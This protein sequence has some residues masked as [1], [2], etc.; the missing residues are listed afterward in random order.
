MNGPASV[1]ISGAEDAVTAIADQLR[2]DGRRVHQLAVSHAFHSPLMDPMID[3]FGTVAAGLTVGKPSIPIVS[4]LTGQLA[5][6]DFASAGVLEAAR[7]RRG[8]VR[9]QRP[10][11]AFGRRNPF[12]RSRAQRGLTASIEESLADAAVKPVR[13]AQGPA[14]ADEPDQRRR[15]GIRLR[16]GR[17]LA[18]VHSAQPIS[19][20]CRPMPLSGGGFGSPVMARRPM[21]PVWVWPPGEHA[22]LGA[23]VEL[24][25]SGGVL[26]T[27]RLSTSTQGW[28]ADHAVGGVVLFPG[29]GFVE[30]AIRAGDEVGCGMVDELNLAAPLVLPAGG[31]V[32]IQVVVGGPDADGRPCGVGVFPGRR[33]L[34]LGIAR[35]RHRCARDRRSRARICPTWPPV[36]AVPVDIGDG[37]ERLADAR[38]RLWTG[39]PRVDRDVA[40]RR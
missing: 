21:L 7:P 2:D 35:R 12:P 1:V 3:E 38:L 33:R 13:P 17:G 34:R 16:H 6:D 15:S 20:S 22:L 18:D 36:G 9:R 29:A 5:A 39:I 11:R 26:L 24:P 27:G 10:L 31:S 40:S 14:G 25:A 8:A 28:L 4:N 23:V 30:L 19:S 37:Y 32:A